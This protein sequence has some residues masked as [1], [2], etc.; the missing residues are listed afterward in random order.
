M[1]SIV[2]SFI[3]WL[4]VALAATTVWADSANLDRPDPATLDAYH[5][6]EWSWV[7]VW[8]PGRTIPAGATV[9][10]VTVR[11]STMGQHYSGMHLYLYNESGAGAFVGN[12]A[13]QRSFQGQQA[14]QKW[15]VKFYVDRLEFPG[16][17][18]YVA[19]T[20]LLDYQVD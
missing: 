8:D 19:P 11:W 1:R 4:L 10:R 6:Q 5:P 16:N 3:L 15:Y 20:L 9:T 14:R 7:G 12:N 2:K 17:P 13:P 18:L